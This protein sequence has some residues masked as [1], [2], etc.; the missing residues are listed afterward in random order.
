M[1]T[2]HLYNTLT[3]ATHS[4]KE[5][6]FD[7]EFSV[8]ENIKLFSTNDDGKNPSYSP[9]EV[10][11]VEFHRFEGMSDPNDMTIIYALETR[12]GERGVLIDAFGAY[13]DEKI[14]EFV[15]NLKIEHN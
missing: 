3:E 7:R 10:K 2:N 8:D 4:L 9:D 5:R 14:D 1:L 13:S 12:G 6:G 15:K 11:V